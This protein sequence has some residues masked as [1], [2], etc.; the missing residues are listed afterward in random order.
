MLPSRLDI[1]VR[2]HPTLGERQSEV[3]KITENLNGGTY[4]M[5]TRVMFAQLAPFQVVTVVPDIMVHKRASSGDE[6]GEEFILLASDGLWDVFN[7]EEAG[8]FFVSKLPH[9]SSFDQVAF[10]GGKNEG[11]AVLLST[12]VVFR[13]WE[14]VANHITDL[15]FFTTCQARRPFS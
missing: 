8:H 9:G 4:A 10:W 13:V 1:L 15:Y 6:T 11:R 3:G 5:Y 7:N 14:L 12:I 2:S